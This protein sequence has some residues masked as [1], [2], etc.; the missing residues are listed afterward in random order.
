MPDRVN[1]Y[2]DGSNFYK[3][4]KDALGR[5]NIDF[6]K[7]AA[8]L[9]GGRS[10]VRIYYYIAALPSGYD[11]TEKGKQEEFFRALDRIPYLELRK[12]RMVTRN[13]LCRAC[14]KSTEKLQEK[15]VDMRLGVDMVTHAS[16]GL[17]D[18]CILVSGDGDY[19]HAVQAVKDLGRHVEVACFLRSRSN[20]LLKAADRMHE[21]DRSF[22][23]DLYRVRKNRG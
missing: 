10:L 9:V 21:L 16:K 23:S 2:I 8:K 4:C 13:I 12:G 15:G 1:V 19:D 17:C 6:G 20:A 5:V 7:F 14:S 11:A 22:F 3:A 18:V